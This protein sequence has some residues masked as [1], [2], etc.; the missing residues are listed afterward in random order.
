MILNKIQI[1]LDNDEDDD[2]EKENKLIGTEEK[3]EE[4]ETDPKKNI[5]KKNYKASSLLDLKLTKTPG[6]CYVGT[7]RNVRT[8]VQVGVGDK[9]ASGK[10]FQQWIYV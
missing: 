9:C 8:C 3:E 4:K 1:I 7:D 10:Y 5:W 6:Y 2:N